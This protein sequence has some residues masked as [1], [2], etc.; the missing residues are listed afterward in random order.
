MDAFHF[1]FII[2]IV[3]FSDGFSL[4]ES[5]HQGEHPKIYDA[6]LNQNNQFQHY[7]IVNNQLRLYTETPVSRTHIKQAVNYFTP[8]INN[9]L[10]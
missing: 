3:L 5:Q 9:S 2:P 6:K 10:P 7:L 1:Y 8:L 4:Y